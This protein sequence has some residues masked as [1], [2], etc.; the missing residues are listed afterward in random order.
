[1]P[2]LS[3]L[4]ALPALGI[5]LLGL[6]H[7]FGNHECRLNRHAASTVD[8]IVAMQELQGIIESLLA[9]L[10]QK[11]G[12]RRKKDAHEAIDV[13]SGDLDAGV[14]PI[15]MEELRALI[16]RANITLAAE[17][18]DRNGVLVQNGQIVREGTIHVANATESGRQ[19]A[20]ESGYEARTQQRL[21]DLFPGLKL[22]D[23]HVLAIVHAGK[24]NVQSSID[25]L[26]SIVW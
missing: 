21:Q 14:G 2:H 4:L 5:E 15:Q 1:V 25:P 11:L 10:G 12:T 17:R 9:E 26:V 19:D 3:V 6:G 8:Q 16:P 20:G 24:R 22:R 23:D 7:R 18:T 13:L